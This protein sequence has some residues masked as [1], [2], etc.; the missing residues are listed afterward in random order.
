MPKSGGSLSKPST[1]SAQAKEVIRARII[2]GEIGADQIYSVPS[3]AAAFGVSATPVREAMVELVRDGLVEV[4][5]NQGFR[6]V[7]LTDH[8]LDEIFQVRLFL[9][10]QGMVAVASGAIDQRH[11]AQY[12][13]LALQIEECAA[14][15]DE[16]GFLRTDR[17]FH[18]GLLGILGNDRLVDIVAGLRDQAR[19]YGVPT[20]GRRGQ[21]AH[22]AHEHREILHALVA[23]DIELVASLAQ[24][25][26]E[27]TRGIWANRTELV[28][29]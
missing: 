13:K 27:H 14:A 19:L 26:I 17:A 4:V 15:D 11:E 18:L 8:D 6:V 24:Q 10:V 1:L 5:P 12:E 2:T 22:S 23:H 20:L 21:L 9:E 7:Q 16:V 25:H 3:L 29:E 28:S